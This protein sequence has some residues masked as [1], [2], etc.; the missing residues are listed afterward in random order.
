MDKELKN[1]LDSDSEFMENFKSAAPGTYRHCDNVAQLCDAV[2]DKITY[3]NRDVLYPAA[4][5][6][7]IGKIFKPQYFCENQKDSNPHDTL[8]PKESYE[9]LS[10]HVAD[11]LLILIQEPCIPR[12]VLEV[13]SQH[14]GNSAIKSICKTEEDLKFFRYRSCPPKTIEACTLMICDVIEATTRALFTKNKL[15]N[16]KQIIDEKINQLVDDVQLDALKIGELRQ[17]KEVLIDEIENLYHKRIDYDE[18]KE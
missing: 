4:K 5:L 7:D 12:K 11:G 2:C 17:I 3:I 10:R 18:I 9:I 16:I 8:T 6:H 15:D 13:I 1:L 14:H